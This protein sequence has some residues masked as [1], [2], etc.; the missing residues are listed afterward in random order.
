MKRLRSILVLGSILLV[1]VVPALGQER[2]FLAGNFGFTFA[3][4]NAGSYGATV[5][6]NVTPAVQ[7][8]G[9]Y[10]HMNDVLTGGLSDFLRSLSA[11]TGLQI[12]GELPVDYGAAGVRFNIDAQDAA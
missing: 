6:V 7:I 8:V 5:G 11:G 12:E 9:L 4:N 2:G 10:S 1:G 3:Q